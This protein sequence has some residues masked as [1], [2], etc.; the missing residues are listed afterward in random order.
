MLKRHVTI[1]CICLAKMDAHCDGFVHL[2]EKRWQLSLRTPFCTFFGKQNIGTGCTRG[3]GG[4]VH[5]I[6]IRHHDP[7]SERKVALWF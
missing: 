6:A 5:P 4:S 1:Q 7:F 3:S 2:E